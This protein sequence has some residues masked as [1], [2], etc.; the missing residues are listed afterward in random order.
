M[1]CIVNNLVAAI[2]KSRFRFPVE[3]AIVKSRKVGGS[4]FCGFTT[5]A[6]GALYGL[7]AAATVSCAQVRS[8]TNALP[9]SPP[10]TPAQTTRAIATA[11]TPKEVPLWWACWTNYSTLTNGR[12]PLVWE[13]RTPRA[14]DGKPAATNWPVTGQN[15]KWQPNGLLTGLKGLTAL[16][17]GQSYDF[18]QSPITAVTR[19]HGVSRGHGTVATPL[20][21]QIVTN[22]ARRVFFLTTNNVIV[23]RDTVA[24]ISHVGVHPVRGVSYDWTFF[25]FDEPLPDSVEIARNMESRFFNPLLVA[26]NTNGTPLPVLRPCQHGLVTAIPRWLLRPQDHSPF[27]AGDSGYPDWLPLPVDGGTELVLVGNRSSGFHWLPAQAQA[28]IDAL[29]LHVGG[30]TNDYPLQWLIP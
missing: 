12:S 11:S 7:T 25:V 10:P 17:A 6:T 3:T 27:L 21:H 22:T 1:R 18:S 5:A 20:L 8:D 9:P 19:R 26:A 23:P 29:T 30:S 15:V 24:S 16:A 28:D 2:V 13:Y 14:V 4:W